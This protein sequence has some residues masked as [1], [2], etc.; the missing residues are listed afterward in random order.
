[1]ICSKCGSKMK[2]LL[3]SSYCDCEDTAIAKNN[4]NDKKAGR[5]NEMI[6]GVNFFYEDGS[7]PVE[8]IGRPFSMTC[9]QPDDHGQYTYKWFF[10]INS[11]RTIVNFLSSVYYDHNDKDKIIADHICFECDKKRTGS[12]VHIYHKDYSDE[13]WMFTER[14]IGLI[15]GFW[16]KF[17]SSS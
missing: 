8:Y 12:F 14:E 1:M 5:F 16:H 7:P 4:I 2:L 11:I 15:V 17:L 9:R 6:G 13:R 3:T 10:S